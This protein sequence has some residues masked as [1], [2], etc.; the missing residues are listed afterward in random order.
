MGYRKSGPISGCAKSAST[1]RFSA[2]SRARDSSIPA[3][4]SC[5]VGSVVG[6]PPESGT[7]LTVR[8][9]WT[10][11]TPRTEVWFGA[12]YS[13]RPSSRCPLVSPRR[14]K[15]RWSPPRKRSTTS[16]SNTLGRSTLGA[17]VIPRSRSAAATRLVRLPAGSLKTRNVGSWEAFTWESAPT[18]TNRSRNARS[19]RASSS[20]ARSRSAR[21]LRSASA[22]A[23]RSASAASSAFAPRIR[24]TI[25]R[26]SGLHR[27]PVVGLNSTVAP[28]SSI[29]PSG[30]PQYRA[31]GAP[32]RGSKSVGMSSRLGYASAGGSTLR[33]TARSGS[34]DTSLLRAGAIP[35]IAARMLANTPAISR[36]FF[37]SRIRKFT[38]AKRP[39]SLL[40]PE[41][42][43]EMR[44]EQRNYRR[45]SVAIACR[46][47]SKGKVELSVRDTGTGIP[48]PYRER[49][50]D[51]FFRTPWR[52]LARRR[53][54]LGDRQGDRRSPRRAPLA[55]RRARAGRHLPLRAASLR[56]VPAAT[57]GF[58]R[59]GRTGTW[60]LPS[61]AKH[62]CVHGRFWI[63]SRVPVP[64]EQGWAEA[65]LASRVN[66]IR[67]IE[68]AH[69]KA[70]KAPRRPPWRRSVGRPCLRAPAQPPGGA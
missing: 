18:F 13:S 48:K 55:R 14:E 61:P 46:A 35:T 28:T 49:V 58:A 59:R 11:T 57:R 9:P 37:Q 52:D 25:S 23:R 30:E 64:A 40:R 4:T 34:I 1:K 6:T 45:G 62:T 56:V 3:P 68:R 16:G 69:R 53:P 5:R 7:T 36:V 51:R 41:Q 22:F 24:A 50:F 2:A 8:C 67:H 63:L 31:S 39:F 33:S 66:E 44:L 26:V 17:T 10:L 38:S 43:A 65:R 27:S 29:P 47:T 12:L 19:R 70:P 20:T 21:A 54:R 15:S 42:I 32:V 60:D